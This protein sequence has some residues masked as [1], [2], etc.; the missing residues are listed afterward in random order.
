MA[1][2]ASARAVSSASAAAAATA[3]GA[4]ELRPLPLPAPL[5]NGDSLLDCTAARAVTGGPART[6]PLRGTLAAEDAG[7]PDLGVVRDVGDAVAS[8]DG[9]GGFLAATADILLLVYV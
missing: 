2:T 1:A 6:E 8:R 7:E 5:L 3:D 4:G 9:T